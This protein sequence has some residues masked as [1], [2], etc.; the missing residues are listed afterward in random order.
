MAVAFNPADNA[1]GTRQLLSELDYLYQYHPSRGAYLGRAPG[2]EEGVA[3]NE[4]RPLLIILQS[5]NDQATGKFFP[6]GQTFANTLNLH[7]L[8]QGSSARRQRTKSIRERVPD[9]H[10]RQ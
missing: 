5:E 7:S 1:I 9:P 2:A 8:G 10:A 6:I 3:M 4:N